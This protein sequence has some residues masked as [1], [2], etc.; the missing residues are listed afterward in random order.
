MDRLSIR[1]DAILLLICS[2]PPLY[3]Q[4]NANGDK[5]L[6]TTSGT[7]TP[8]PPVTGVGTA[9]R[10]PMRDTTSDI[11]NSV[12]FQKAST[13]GISTTAPAATL[14][15]NGKSDIRDTLTLFPK[16]TDNTLA[17]SGTAF[18]ISN[19]GAVT[20]ISGQKFPGAGT[21]TGI[22]TA[23]GSGLSGGGTTGTLSLKVAPAGV[24]N[25]MLQNSHITLNANAAGGIAAPGA[26]TLGS[27]ATIG[28]KACA[29]NQVLKFSGT[30]WNCSSTG[31][32]T[33]TGVFA[34]TDLTGGGTAG[35]VTLNLDT[36]KVPQLAAA[37]NFTNNQTVT[38]TGS[39]FALLVAPPTAT[40][41]GA[42]VP[43]I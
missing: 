30:V 2:Y 39:G 29:T 23:S 27:T 4:E 8:N 38:G 6:T 15:V 33:I 1:V 32:G 5:P 14:D 13:I 35:N 26:M 24:S 10:I 36:T 34:G 40:S 7:I 37:N 12:M 28:L 16:S 19:T 11:I 9:G 22:T 18:K 3:A 25:A 31:T 20:F 43:A 42:G 41:G 17:I 21:I